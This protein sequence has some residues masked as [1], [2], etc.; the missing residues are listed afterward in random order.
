[1]KKMIAV[2]LVALGMV[3]A[4]ERQAQAWSKFNFGVG[5]NLGWEG[6]GNNLLWGLARGQNVPGAGP[7]GGPGFAPGAYGPGLGHAAAPTGAPMGMAGGYGTMGAPQ[8]YGVAP[9]GFPQGFGIPP[10]AQPQGYGV[11]PYGGG[12]GDF[13]PSLIG[14][15]G[16]GPIA[17]TFPTGPTPKPM[18]TGVPSVAQPVGYFPYADP[19]VGYYP[20]YYYGR[21]AR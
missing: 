3:L 19:A 13:D 15:D 2:G 16:R 9:F 20:A 10:Y 7:L 14:P 1:M 18:P 17:P 21:Y 6:G 4:Q 8:G 11:A 5:L 12:F